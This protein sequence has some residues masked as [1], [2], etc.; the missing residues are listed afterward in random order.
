M[1]PIVQWIVASAVIGISRILL[2][3][4]YFSDVLAGYTS[5]AA[6]LVLCI[7]IAGHLRGSP[8]AAAGR[9]PPEPRP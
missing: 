2:Q 6:W 7:G 9:V 4:H 5:G 8:S 3:V 1:N